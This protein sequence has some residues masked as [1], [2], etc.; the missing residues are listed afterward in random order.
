MEMLC[1]SVPSVVSL[2]PHQRSPSCQI[3]CPLFSL[4]PYLIFLW[5]WTLP[6]LPF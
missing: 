2:Y 1:L 5:C 4:T 3:Q 6:F